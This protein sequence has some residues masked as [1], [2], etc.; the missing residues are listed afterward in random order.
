MYGSNFIK[1]HTRILLWFEISKML[2]AVQQKNNFIVLFI[3]SSGSAARPVT[4][5]II[6]RPSLCVQRTATTNHS[7]NRRRSCGSESAGTMRCS[8]F[9]DFSR[10]PV[11]ETP[12]M[13]YIGPTL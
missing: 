13:G 11:T 9:V 4:M 7:H 3:I 6:T 8:S 5:S 12:R 10:L 1:Q 2:I